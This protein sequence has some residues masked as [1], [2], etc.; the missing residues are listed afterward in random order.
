MTSTATTGHD[1]ELWS[2]L[3]RLRRL[4]DWLV[5]AA[6]PGRAAAALRRHVPELAAGRVT[7]AG[8]DPWRFRLKGPTWDVLYRL[9]LDEPGRGRRVVDLFGLVHA[10]GQAPPASAPAAP[11]G[12]PGWRC[13]LPELGLDLG[14]VPADGG[15]PALADLRDP[16][17]ARA[18]LEAGIRACSP[19]YADLRI[20]RCRP[21]LL[22]CN[23]DSRA[24]LRC[25]LGYPPQAAGRGWPEVVVVKT[26]RG[27]KGRNAWEAMRALWDSPLGG[28]GGEVRLAEPLAWIPERRV[29]VQGPIP[30]ERTLT[31]LLRRSLRLGTPAALDELRSALDRTAAALAALH[32]RG[33]RHGTARTLDQ[34][35]DE[36]GRVAARLAGPV[37]A[38]AGAAGPLLARLAALAAGTPADP[39][40]PAHRSFRPGQVLLRDGGIG[41]ID[42][43]GFCT[44]EPALDVALFRADLKDTGMLVRL[45]GPPGRDRDLAMAARLE[46]L[47]DLFLDR[48]ARHA[49][50]SPR[51][52]ALWEAVDLLTC[53]LHS[54]TKV[55]PRRLATSRLLLERHLRAARS[56]RG[57]GGT[58]GGGLTAVAGDAGARADGAGR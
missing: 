58:G 31:Q 48:Y 52:V 2:G 41:L 3:E 37:P 20:A 55:Q 45:D 1:G 54:W 53:V 49:P 21:L 23:P 57:G 29:L 42:F 11:L 14:T 40:G 28:S 39:D 9:A 33:P 17:R 6:D 32:R 24:T 30:A 15:L 38:L 8:C 13:A 36:A 19:A 10:P 25:Q 4:P 18:L 12:A 27:D 7:L 50:V 35:L 5:A 46:E 26:H 44:A 22:R 34:E 51:R 47:A 43:D 16:E 56:D